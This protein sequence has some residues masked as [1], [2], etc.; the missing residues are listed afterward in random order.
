M[1]S[2]GAKIAHWRGPILGTHGESLAGVCPK[3]SIASTQKLRWSVKALI[4]GGS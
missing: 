3:K 4:S 2:S 1:G